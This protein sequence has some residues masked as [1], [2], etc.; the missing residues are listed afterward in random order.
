MTNRLMN[1][2]M[3]VPIV[4][5]PSAMHFDEISSVEH[6]AFSAAVCANFFA[7]PRMRRSHLYERAKC[8]MSALSAATRQ[9]G[10]FAAPQ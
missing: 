5:S 6:R 4:S 1:A 10:A 3:A 9:I 7:V 2:R 8:F